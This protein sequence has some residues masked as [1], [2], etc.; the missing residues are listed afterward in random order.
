MGSASRTL[1]VAGNI[2]TGKTHLLDTI[3]R[4]LALRTFPERWED[5]PWFSVDQH[6]ELL[7][8]LWF[9][10]ASGSDQTQM[11]I[12]GGVQERSIHEH[13]QVF[14]REQLAGEDLRLLL[15]VHA[16]LDAALPDPQLLIYLRAPVSELLERVRVRGRAQEQ[17][18]TERQ[19]E[20]LQARY[21]ELIAGWTRC[22]VIEID[23]ASIDVR[24]TD[25]ARHVLDRTTEMLR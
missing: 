19:L 12:G 17:S 13:A 10:L 16:R 6:D 4:A 25:G 2:A 23:T 1:V 20:R 7:A 8:Q 15:E 14:A 21:D 9:L 11:S 3:G 24:S 5:N 18:L 22:P